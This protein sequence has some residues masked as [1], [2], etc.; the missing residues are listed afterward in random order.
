MALEESLYVLQTSPMCSAYVKA[1]Q[2]PTPK[3]QFMFRSPVDYKTINFLNL[4]GFVLV[5]KG[6]RNYTTFQLVYQFN[7]L[8]KCQ[9]AV[10]NG[11]KWSMRSI[12]E[13][14]S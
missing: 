10:N 8:E 7:S 12:R 4:C 3:L 13:S 2:H 5:Y 14:G 11:K 6:M 9:G 1:K